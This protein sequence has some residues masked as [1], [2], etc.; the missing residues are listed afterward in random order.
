MNDSLDQLLLPAGSL[1]FSEGDVGEVAYLIRRGEIEIFLDRPSGEVSLARRSA[2]EIIGEMAIIDRLPRSA[3]ARILA[4]AELVLITRAQIEHR[5]NATDPILR[6]CLGVVIERYRETV[7]LLRSSADERAIQANTPLPS[8]KR[9]E[10]PQFRAALDMLSL[11][12]EL[13]RGLLEREFEIH[14]QPIVALAS[15]RLAGFEALIR[16]NHPARG[17]L[18]PSHF[19][20]VAEASGLIIGMTQWCLSEVA[21]VYPRLREAASANPD[22]TAE[23]GPF[24]SVNVSGHDLALPGFSQSVRETLAMFGM[25]LER[26]KLEVTES[27]LMRDPEVASGVLRECRDAGMGIAIDDFGTGYSSLSYLAT[28]P[29]STLK[30]DRA[31]VRSLVADATSAKIVATILHLARDLGVP[32]V[33][34]GIEREVEATLLGAL[35]CE[36]G[37][38]YL[39]GRPAPLADATTFAR[40]WRGLA[41]AP[42]NVVALTG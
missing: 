38:G 11:E 27:I 34:E 20:P 39:Y 22:W 24:V 18:A 26:L 17:R 19:I 37:Q 8:P 30:I 9:S 40:T 1:L 5:I 10:A 14:F 33:A 36:Y 31:F 21:R 4:E 42:S 15:S 41:C 2:G 25:P 32:V 13:K 12:R 35:A 29:I 3:S 23:D 7:G 16:W 28:L 6:M